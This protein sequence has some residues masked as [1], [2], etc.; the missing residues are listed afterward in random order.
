MSILDDGSSALAC[1]FNI[2]VWR[3]SLMFE[4]RKGANEY[5]VQ[6]ATLC[7]EQ[8]CDG[9]NDIGVVGRIR[10]GERSMRLARHESMTSAGSRHQRSP[11]LS[12]Q[13]HVQDKTTA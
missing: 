6:Y 2:G 8:N 5:T 10:K 11:N 4:K 1:V 3:R 12:G 13:T 7:R 9:N